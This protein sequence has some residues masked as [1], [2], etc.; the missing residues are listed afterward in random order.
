MAFLDIETSRSEHPLDVV[1]RLASVNNWSFDREDD[2]E[3]SLTIEGTRGAYQ[4]ALTW[5]EDIEALHVSCAF[6]LSV[7]D[8]RRD[9][10]RNLLLLVNERLWVGHFDL[11]LNDNLVM[12]R[13]SLL[14]AGGTQPNGVQCSVLLK[15]AVEACDRYYDAFH[16]VVWANKTGREALDTAL[17]ETDGHA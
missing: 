9:E 10:A 15:F 4:V 13:H 11:W 8:R 3:I 16:F 6:D 14:L 7:P 1:E 2:N 12:F 17:F 5:L